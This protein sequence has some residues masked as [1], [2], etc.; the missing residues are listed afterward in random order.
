MF[1]DLLFLYPLIV[2]PGALCFVWGKNTSD[3]YTFLCPKTPNTDE[4]ASMLNFNLTL[5]QRAA[6]KIKY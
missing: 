1:W 4:E 6:V 3:L 5:F 2:E